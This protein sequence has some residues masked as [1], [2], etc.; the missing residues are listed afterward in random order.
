VIGH[1]ADGFVGEG[2]GVGDGLFD[3]VGVIRPAMAR[4]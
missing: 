2:L 1:L 4:G 3:R